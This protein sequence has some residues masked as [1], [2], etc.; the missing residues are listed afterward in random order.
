MFFVRKVFFFGMMKNNSNPCTKTPKFRPSP[1]QGLLSISR[2]SSL[3]WRI[4][5][6]GRHWR[7][8]PD[9]GFSNF[10][11]LIRKSKHS[12]SLPPYRWFDPRIT[13]SETI[14]CIWRLLGHVVGN[15]THKC[16]CQSRS[17]TRSLMQFPPG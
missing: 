10:T 3:S 13:L 17:D 14:F 7:Q 8:S 12:P 4:A 9:E 11:K 6:R 5:V 15:I 1:V 2:K 16:N